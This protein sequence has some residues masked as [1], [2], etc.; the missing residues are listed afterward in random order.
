M[1]RSARRAACVGGV[2]VCASVRHC[3]V[4]SR[5]VTPSCVTYIQLLSTRA[6]HAPWRRLLCAHAHVTSPAH[7]S[8]T[9]Y[10]HDTPTHT[11]THS[12]SLVSCSFSPCLPHR[13]CGCA[14]QV[15]CVESHMPYKLQ[16][17]ATTQFHQQF[18]SRPLGLAFHGLRVRHREITRRMH[19]IARQYRA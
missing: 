17:H 13:S 16:R 4:E 18:S 11:E 3:E 19:G 1:G 14:V 5:Y 10:S 8:H 9:Y 6:V 15:W 7:G 2:S 12:A